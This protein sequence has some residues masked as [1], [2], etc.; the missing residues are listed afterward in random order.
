MAAGALLMIGYSK[1][2]IFLWVNWH[3]HS[4][5]DFYFKWITQLGNGLFSA[6]LVVALLFVKFRYAIIGAFS[7]ILTGI[8]IQILKHFVFTDSLRPVK[9]FEGLVDIR[10]IEGVNMHLY[11]SFPSGHTATA[12][13][14]FF[15]IAIITSGMDKTRSFFVGGFCFF[16]AISVGVSRVYL[17][18]HFFAD[19]Y[20]GA[21]IGV[22]CTVLG[23]WLFNLPR[24]DKTA[25][26]EKAMLSKK[27]LF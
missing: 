5:A 20:L 7:F 4:L 24:F 26:F 6:L 27:S 3:H 10:T 12:F 8:T 16:L 9:Y 19:I 22:A 11:H 13:S 17:S 14:L 18:Q 25:W 1:E 15:L 2:Q 21:I 23:V